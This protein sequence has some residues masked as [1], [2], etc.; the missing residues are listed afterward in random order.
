MKKKF[1]TNSFS[2]LFCSLVCFFYSRTLH[3]QYFPGGFAKNKIGIWLDARDSATLTRSSGVI[4]AWRDKANNLSAAQSTTSR[5]P[6]LSY[7]NG[8][9]IIEFDSLQGLDIPDTTFLDP[10]FGYNLAQVVYVY[11]DAS[12]SV[13]DFRNGTYSRNQSQGTP[14]IGIRYVAADGKY[15]VS[16]NRNN[17]GY[18]ISNYP[19]MRGKW[20]LVDNFVPTDN[21]NVFFGYNAKV[22]IFSPTLTPGTAPNY[23][24]SATVGNR[25][26]FYADVH[27]GVCE[28]VLSSA[29]LNKAGRKILQLYLSNKWNLVDTVAQTLTSLYVPSNNNFVNNLVGIG[30]EGNGDSVSFNGSNNGL[31]FQNVNGYTGFL[32][33]SG[34]YLV[35]ADNALTGTVGAGSG[36]TRWNRSWYV[37]KTDINGY[38]GL[39]NLFFDFNTY[40]IANALDTVNNAY[41]LLY[42]PANGYFNSG[43]N[44]VVPVNNYFQLA[45]TSQIY[46]QLD[47][48]NVADGYYT[49]VYAPRGTPITNISLF[50]SFTPATFN[51]TGTPAVSKVFSGNT[52]NYLIIDSSVVP[53]AIAYYKIYAGKNGAAL[54][55]IDSTASVTPYFAHYNIQNDSVYTYAVS[56]VYAPGKEGPISRTISGTPNNN[57][58]AWQSVPQYSGSGKIAMAAYAPAAF[59]PLKFLFSN[60]SGGGNSTSYQRSSAYTDTGLINGNTYSYRYKLM[61]TVRGVSTESAWSSTESTVLADSAKGGF[62]YNLGYLDPTTIW[63]PYG[64]GPTN[65]LPS[66]QDMST[67]RYIKNAPAV[68]LHPRLYCN[69]ED[70]TSIR[71]RLKNTRSGVSAAK[72]IHAYTTLLQLGNSGYNRNAYYAKDTL[73]YAYVSNT[74]AYDVKAFYDSLALGDI[75]VRNNYANYWGGNTVKMAYIFAMEAMECWLYRG[76]ID[77]VTNTSYTTRATKLA[78]AITVWARKALADVANPLSY[79]NRTNFGAVH[80]AY[81]YDFLHNQMTKNQQDT[82]RMA[83]IKMLPDSSQLHGFMTP[84]YTYISNWATFGYE[85][86]PNLI[87]EGEPGYAAKDTGTVRNWCRSTWNFLTHGVYDKTGNVYEGLGKDQLNVPLLVALAKRGYSMLGHPSVSSYGKKYLPALIQPFGYSFVGTDLL[88]GTGLNNYAMGLTDDPATGSWK[89]NSIDPIGLKWAF[90]ADTAVDFVWKNYMQRLKANM[91]YNATL[92]PTYYAYSALYDNY[93]AGFNTRIPGLIFASDYYPTAFATQ[94]QGA[95]GGNKMYFDSLGGFATLRSGFD[96]TATTVFFANRQDLGGHTYGNKNEFLLSALGRIWIPRPTSMANSEFDNHAFTGA[97]T[98]ILVNGYGVSVDTGAFNSAARVPGKIVHYGNKSDMLSI[99]GDATKAYSYNWMSQFGGY[100]GDNPNLNPPYITAVM[101]NQNSFRYSP[102]YS[103][104]NIPFYNTL[105]FTDAVVSPSMP[106]YKRYVQEPFVNGVMKKVFRTIS[107][108]Q[109]A[110]PYVIVADDVQRDANV[111]NYK[112]VCQVPSDLSIE[113]TTVNLVN[114]NYQNDIVLREAGSRRLLVRVL[115][116]NGAVNANLP[117]VIDSAVFQFTKMRR[118]VIESNS[119]DPQFKVMLF[120]FNTG[121]SLP[122]TSWNPDKTRIYVTHNGTT[123]TIS[124]NIDSAGRTN[125]GLNSPDTGVVWT[126]AVN[127]NWHNTANWSLGSIP[128]ASD[129]VIIP[130]LGITNMPVISANT[131]VAKSL[132]VYAGATLRIDSILQMGGDLI[133]DGQITGTGFLKTTSISTTPLPAAKTWNVL[134]EFC[135]TN[136]AQ[137]IPSGTYNAG[138]RLN[139]AS[140]LTATALGNCTVN[141]VLAVNSGNS[142]NMDVYRLVGSITSTSGTGN[143]QTQSTLNPCLPSGVYWLPTVNYNAVAGGQFVA[144]GTYQNLRLTPINIGAAEDSTLGNIAVI[145]TLNLATRAILDIG[146]AQLGGTLNVQLGNGTIATGNTSASALPANKVWNG[147]VWY[148]SNNT[149]TVVTGSYNN[150]NLSSAQN[151]NRILGSVTNSDTIIIRGN[152]TPPTGTCNPNLTT[153]LFNGNGQTIQGTTFYNLDLTGA[154]ATSFTNSTITILNSF[155]PA[156]ISTANGFGTFNFAG[157]AGQTIPVFAYNNLTVSNNTTTVFPAGAT[158]STNTQLTINGTSRLDVGTLSLSDLTG[159][160]PAGIG[161]LVTSN[162]SAT[163]LPSGRTWSFGIEFAAANATQTIPAGTYFNLLISSNSGTDT[164]SGNLTVSGNLFVNTGSVLDLRGFSLSV[165]GAF[166]NTG[167]GSIRTRGTIPA[168]L[169]WTSSMVFNST[170]AFYTIVPGN[171]T[172]IDLDGGT[173]LGRNID[174]GSGVGSGT[175]RVSGNITSTTTSI[176]FNRTTFILNGNNQTIANGLNYYNLRLDSATNF[177]YPTS[178]NIGHQLVPGSSPSAAPSGTTITFIVPGGGVSQIFDQTI[179]SFNYFNLTV[180][181]SRGTFSEIFSGTIGVAGTFSATATFSTG[182]FVTDN[183][184]FNFN[185]TGAQTIPAFSYNHLTISGTRSGNITLASGTIN[186]AGDY[187]RSAIFTSGSMVVTN[188]TLNFNGIVHQSINGSSALTFNKL[189]FTNTRSGGGIISLQTAVTVND[190]C[191]LTSGLVNLQN[192]NLTLV[193]ALSGGS[194]SAYIYTNGTGVLT[195]NNV[196]NLARIFPIGTAASYTPL[197]ITNTSGTSNISVAAASTFTNSVANNN[198]MVNVQWNISGSAS[199]TA[200]VVYQYNNTDFGSTFNP[201]QNCELGIYTNQYTTANIGIPVQNGNVYSDTVTGIALSASLRYFVIGNVGAI[202]CVVGTWVGVDGAD[203]N[204]ATNWC[205]G[206]PNGS[207]NVIIA[208]TAPRLT[209]NLSV[210]NLQLATGIDVNGNTL[211]INGTITGAGAIKGSVASNLVLNGKGTINFNQSVDRTSNALN[212]LTINTTDTIRLGSSVCVQGF[213]HPTA[214]TLMLGNQ[215]ITLMSGSIAN[216]AQV[217][218]VGANIVYNGTGRFITER[219]LN[220]AR[221]GYRNL[222]SMGVYS[223]GG[224]YDNWQEGATNN[225]LNPAPGYGMHITG[226]RGSFGTIDANTGLDA[227]QSGNPSLWQ[228]GLNDNFV[229]VTNTK[230]KKLLPFEGYFAVVR[231]SR[232][233]DLSSP[234]PSFDMANTTL[235]V[236][237]RLTTGSVTLSSNANPSWTFSGLESSSCRL[238]NNTTPAGK[239]NGDFGFSLVANPYAC[240]IDWQKVYNRSVALSAGASLSP[241]Y[242]VW[243]QAANNNNGAYVTVHQN[244]ITT[245]PVNTSIIQP[246][247]SFFIQNDHSG[248]HVVLSFQESDKITDKNAFPLKS[249][250]D[251]QS[252]SFIHVN[253]VKSV[254]GSNTA[255][256]ADGAVAILGHYSNAIDIQ[257]AAKYINPSENIAWKQEGNLLSVQARNTPKVGDSLSLFFSNMSKQAAYQ[258]QVKIQFLADSV[259]AWLLDKTTNTKIPLTNN[260]ISV[261]DVQVGED[262]LALQNRYA[263]VFGAVEVLPLNV[264]TLVLNTT[265][266][267]IQLQCSYQ[268]AKQVA[269]VYLE[270]STDGRTFEVNDSV[271][272][273]ATA[274]DWNKSLPQQTTFYRAKFVFKDGNMAYTAIVTA[275]PL[276]TPSSFAVYPSLVTGK[277]FYMQ[278]PVSANEYQLTMTDMLGKIILTQKVSAAIAKQLIRLPIQIASGTYQVQLFHQQKSVYNT[279]IEIQ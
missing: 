269:K 108:I 272:H 225:N 87:V 32:R 160:T 82:V 214:G 133:C 157:T 31:G 117:A 23:T 40:G 248:N 216:T 176:S 156:N 195:R 66:T 118:L 126:G 199:T 197:T 252:T 116:N 100:Q 264:G 130:S 78:N 74:G 203:A 204:N 215:N 183:S 231:G 39:V 120:A 2:I 143:I 64:I 243:N 16:V 20:G 255:I 105:I 104:D 59:L 86:I 132:S 75:G 218:V 95:F 193:G 70:S 196:S 46:F 246:G 4:S 58:P 232:A 258:L 5:R 151:G 141:G 208:N 234:T 90:P 67:V 221:R 128:T 233:Y 223:D 142:L 191:T 18:Y 125:I 127:T 229:A 114:N 30:T 89:Q 205:G 154:F 150:L 237:G 245:L 267:A 129:N 273:F 15:E 211:I 97:S 47:A 101:D 123:N 57:P 27:W 159:I 49:L 25:N 45:G 165:G 268:G 190:T 56:A 98:G 186:I 122:V 227:T 206:L 60:V 174:Q 167:S 102:F 166:T 261:V 244:G 138:L 43:N 254:A 93:G 162:T 158:L 139:M 107:L 263:I 55:A 145:D 65:V 168:N 247:Q 9:P 146:T 79:D 236:R 52:F 135:S 200:T 201:A 111:N 119:I 137:N 242:W 175:F 35:A 62:T 202:N 149:Q 1:Y 240:A 140:G 61:D 80:M 275:T 212:N 185:G 265:K 96:S 26:Q 21:Q 37:D 53:Y 28:T 163:P 148:Y 54:T 188:N 184:T 22:D 68:G 189:R 155:K 161:T 88:G 103:Y 169:T 271:L 63:A 71:W 224:I 262:S 276:N 222:S 210:N 241:Y 72:W 73:G 179:P 170:V 10:Q 76:T 250:F 260:S 42:N 41:Y 217:G 266:T 11:S 7:Q 99:A 110:K 172:N 29:Y 36:F 3:A 277:S 6:K 115:N 85:I 226:I 109:A 14:H 274:Y 124:F 144:G 81:V 192:N 83:L 194:S 50:S 256:V 38:G 207:T 253:L 77:S 259:H 106:Y 239:N 51:L 230:N 48:L 131:A 152:W 198:Q 91:P 134:I 257:D 182:R 19:D 220:N 13:S 92:S 94:A 219:Y 238:N 69:P 84:S 180:S 24:N 8:M 181:G 171:Y 249:V 34:D 178:L 228:Y 112:W 213:L 12:I 136:G 33:E 270:A 187:N 44:Y 164:A 278:M 209:A 17:T 153:V 251:N 121:E 113:S 279:K 147:T 173:G 235:R 177:N